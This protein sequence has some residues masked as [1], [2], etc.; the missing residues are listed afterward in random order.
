MR[1]ILGVIV[2]GLIAGIGVSTAAGALP[3]EP[4]SSSN[5][6]VTA[7]TESKVTR[8]VERN[9]RAALPASERASLAMQ[10]RNDVAILRALQLWAGSENHE[11]LFWVSLGYGNRLQSALDSVESGLAI[12]RADC[13]GSGRSIAANRFKRF[14]CLVTSEVLRIPSV[15]IEISDGEMPA[16]VEDEP[17]LVGPVLTQIR[18]RITGK[19][20]FAYE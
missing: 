12:A 14:Y 1:H 11:D 20:S 18:V 9:A 2:V 13:T 17:R 7:W 5:R 19:S 15:R 4:S 10:L 6:A 3:I 8:I 16:I